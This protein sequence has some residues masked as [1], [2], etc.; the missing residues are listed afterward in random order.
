MDDILNWFLEPC[1]PGQWRF[2]AAVIVI[3]LLLAFIW[4]RLSGGR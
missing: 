3:F 1:P 4:G 2:N